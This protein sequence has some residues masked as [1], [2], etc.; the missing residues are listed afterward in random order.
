MKPI[1]ILNLFTI[2][3]R[4]GAETMVMNYYRH[5][6]RNRIQFDFIVH[7]DKKGAYDDE[8]KE[9]GGRIFHFPPIRPWSAH[10]YRKQ[11]YAF[12]KSHPEYKIIHSNMSEL[13]YDAFKEAAKLHV[14]VLINHAHLAPH[15][16][17]IKSPF[18][19]YMKTNMRHYTTHMF[20]C[21]QAAGDWLYGKKNRPYF[22]QMNNAIDTDLF[23]YNETVRKEVRHE[24]NIGYNQLVIGHVGRFDLQKN[25]QFIIDIFH[26]LHNMNKESVLIL[27]GTGKLIDQIKEKVKELHLEDSVMFLGV[28]SDV[29]RLMQAFDAFLF[30]SLFEGLPVTLV[31]AQAAGLPILMSDAIPKDCI[32]TNQIKSLSLDLSAQEWALSLLSEVKNFYRKDT[33]DLIKEAGFDICSNAHWL[34]KK[35]EELY[36]EQ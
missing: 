4:G 7:R 24:L 22:I 17:D 19:W 6:D 35:Y 16:V 25:H 27:V 8:I 20:T 32:I 3:D 33:S 11:I 10:T 12:L 2:M 15:G 34:E 14:P 9:L 5:I 26:E 23:K 31:E 28:R 30:P 1:R 18:R 13:G 21:S 29:N 36:Y